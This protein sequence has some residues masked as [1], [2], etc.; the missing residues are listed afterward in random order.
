MEPSSTEL[1]VGGPRVDPVGEQNTSGYGRQLLAA[2]RLHVH[3]VWPER[4]LRPA[5]LRFLVRARSLSPPGLW[6]CRE[7]AGSGC[8]CCFSVQPLARLRCTAC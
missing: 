3:C 7:V 5:E 1:L 8:C 4:G 2:R 6:A